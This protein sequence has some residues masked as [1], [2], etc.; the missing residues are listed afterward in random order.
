MRP[1]RI[2]DMTGCSSLWW[3]DN[4][5]HAIEQFYNEYDDNEE[6]WRVTDEQLEMSIRHCNMWDFV[7]DHLEHFG[8]IPCEYEDENEVVWSIDDIIVEMTDEEHLLANAMI[9]TECSN[10]SIHK[11]EDL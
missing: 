8:A 5:N 4:F 3:A 6:I 2:E 10:S 7:Y 11:M 9:L 1:Y